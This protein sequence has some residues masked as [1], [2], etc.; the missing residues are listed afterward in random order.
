MVSEGL[1][2]PRSSP[3][4]TEDAKA[5]NRIKLSAGITSSLLSFALLVLLVTTPGGKSIAGLCLSLCPNPY[6]ALLLFAFSV[7][8]VQSAF[9]LPLAWF[10]S[11]HVEHRFALS[12]QSAAQWVWERIKGFA[13]GA[14]F[15]AGVFCILYYCL[16]R[17]GS[18]WWLPV[19]TALTLISVVL[20]RISPV[21]IMPLFYRFTP[22]VDGTLRERIMRLCESAGVR[23]E[24]IFS[25]NLSKNTRKANAAFTGI[26]RSRR[27]ILGDTLV[28]NF[29]EEEIET[30]FAHELGH[31][32]FGHIRT[33]ILTGAVSTFA[34]LFLTSRL[35]ESSVGL[36]HFS[37]LTDLAAL[38][39]LAIW[40]SLFGLLTSP[41]GNMISRHHERR[42]DAYAVRTT[43]KR[44]AFIAALRKLSDMNLADP[45]PHPLVEFMFYSH[46][47]IAKRIRALEQG[48]P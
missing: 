26:G 34:G 27:I 22:I 45:A 9:T 13:L 18:L 47:P 29:T 28:E 16:G 7:G 36:L 5:Y 2:P 48:Y 31:Y 30:V 15:A 19:G 25:F 1:T 6:G 17:F 10:S 32:R 20:V 24:G 41:I 12:N 42:A 4:R 11:F 43:G 39:L 44:D 40:L 14:P 8:I 37:S 38:P 21:L 46:P 33:A 23:V 35:Y 3:P